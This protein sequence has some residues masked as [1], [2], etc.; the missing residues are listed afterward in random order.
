M[1]GPSKSLSNHSSSPASS[2]TYVK[3]SPAFYKDKLGVKSKHIMDIF[4]SPKAHYIPSSPREFTFLE[5]PSHSREASTRSP[6]TSP[7]KPRFHPYLKSRGTA[8]ATTQFTLDSLQGLNAKELNPGAAL[9]VS[10]IIP[11]C[12]KYLMSRTG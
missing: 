2:Q 10:K 3:V 1:K 7:T 8:A 12:L 9:M 5:T 11:K 6:L 4:S